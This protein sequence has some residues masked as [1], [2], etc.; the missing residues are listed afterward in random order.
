MKPNLAKL[1]LARQI[2]SIV[3]AVWRTK[4]VYDPKRLKSAARRD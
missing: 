3:L 1:T 4:E 2:A